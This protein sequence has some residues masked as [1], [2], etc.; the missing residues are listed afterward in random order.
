VRHRQRYAAAAGGS[1]KTLIRLAGADAAEGETAPLEFGNP[2]HS[3]LIDPNGMRYI[4]AVRERH[5]ASARNS[6]SIGGS[7]NWSRD[8]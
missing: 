4:R 8:R 6:S 1:T 2:K 7:R 3:R 5:S